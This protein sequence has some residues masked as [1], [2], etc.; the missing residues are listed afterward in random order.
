VADDPQVDVFWSEDRRE[1]V[2]VLYAFGDTPER[3]L[4]ALKTMMQAPR[5]HPG[6]F[7]WPVQ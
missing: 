1:Y 7:D 2:A 5:A 6:G 4:A 3:A